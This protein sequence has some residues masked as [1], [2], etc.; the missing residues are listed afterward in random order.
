[1]DA[2]L[3]ILR[4]VKLDSFLPWYLALYAEVQ[5]LHGNHE[6]ALAAVDEAARAAH[7]AGGSFAIPEIERVRRAISG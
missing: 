5:Q 6:A 4:A 2:S 7:S 1:M 3:P